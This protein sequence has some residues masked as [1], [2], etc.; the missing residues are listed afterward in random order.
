MIITAKELQLHHQGLIFHS[1]RGLQYTSG[2]PQKLLKSNDIIPSLSSKGA[3]LDGFNK[4]REKII[5]PLHYI[6]RRP[7]C[8]LC[9]V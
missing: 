5:R 3:C 1:D 6:H 7:F 8:A 2:K 4:L 9:A